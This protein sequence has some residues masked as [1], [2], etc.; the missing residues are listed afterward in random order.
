MNTGRIVIV[1]GGVAANSCA[2]EL[3][4]TGFDGDVVLIAAEADPPYDRTLLSKDLLVGSVDAAD[5]ALA[6]PADYAAASIDLR[7]G[8]RACG[9]DVSERR[10]L[11]DDGRSVSYDRV[12]LATGGVATR[13][14]ALA[15]E[16]VHF[17]RTL[18]DAVALRDELDGAHHLIIVGAGF[19]GGEVAAAAVARG[20]DVTLIEALDAPL[21]HSLGADVG[22]RLGEL[23]RAHGVELLTGTSVA[24]INGRR[25]GMAVTLADGRIVS[26]DTVVVGAGMLPD[27]AWLKG[28]GVLI[29]AGV[30]TDERCATNVDGVFSAGDCARWLNPRYGTLMRAEHWDTARRHG[31]AAARC[32]L[33]VGEPFDPIPFFW[34]HLHGVHFQWV[35]YAP[36]W[37]TVEIE[38]GETTGGFT[39]RYLRDGRPIAMFA[40]GASRAI[41]E[42]RRDLES[43]KEAIA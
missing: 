30:I 20:L 33:G 32:A 41:A 42:A 24:K 27:V 25:H 8:V 37:D 13:P 29:D 26:G 34:S 3:R 14:P 10:V 9:L 31:A 15:R 28:S 17:L 40:A 22:A 11:F 1:G 21:T 19:I 2:L 36:A 12:I 18:G 4:E 23:H 39:A 6:E 16:G 38:E 5:L 43:A 35:G 7:L